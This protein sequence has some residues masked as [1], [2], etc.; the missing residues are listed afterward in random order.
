MGEYVR[1]AADQRWL[2]ATGR[3][4]GDGLDAVC[5]GILAALA[6]KHGVTLEDER[7]Q[8]ARQV[9]ARYRRDYG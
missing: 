7:R 1:H 6:H 2:T 9:D 4:V 5:D 8:L 3:Q